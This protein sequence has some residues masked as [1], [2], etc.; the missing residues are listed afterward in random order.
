MKKWIV[1]G[2]V[3]V[4]VVIGTVAMFRV[5]GLFERGMQSTDDAYITADFTLV[6]PKV[7]G[8]IS[9]VAVED[10]Q[11][12]RAGDL[13][14]SIDDRDYQVALE[15]AQSQ[16]SAAQARLKNAQARETRQHATID[17]ARAAVRA[18]DAAVVFAG[19]NAQRYADLSRQGAGTQEQ[20]QQTSFA[21]RQQAAIRD[22]D[23]AALTAA[24][25]ELG[26]LASEDAEAQAAVTLAGAAVH[27]AELNLSYTKIL[28]PFDGVIGQRSVRVG[29]YVG[30]NTTLLAVVPLSEAY[31]VAN[32]REV[33]LTHMRPGQLA[34][35]KI[36]ALPGVELTGHVD[37][38]S[39]ATG[40]TFAPVAPD[41]ATGNFT[42]VVQR[43]PVKIVLDA[44]QPAAGLLKVGMSVVPKVD[45]SARSGAAR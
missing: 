7:S 12:V 29:A 43:L 45:V 18:D 13:L 31:V 14:A 10:N 2:V 5:A 41:N 21:Q 37:S 24:E 35:V 6:A 11:P 15:T 39:P 19:Q 32:F 20:Q 44:N 23:A 9:K 33:Q 34:R 4:V 38:V 25:K 27:Q 1:I 36:D 17:Q 42:K 26:V 28:A 3:A 16:L 8:L 22:R 40:L 30:P